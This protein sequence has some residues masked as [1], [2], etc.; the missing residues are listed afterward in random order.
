MIQYILF[1]L[2][3]VLSIFI[4]Q[5]INSSNT[6][7]Y[8]NLKKPSWQPPS[9]LFPIV[10]T[11]LYLLIG[12]SAFILYNTIKWKNTYIWSLFWI[13]LII[14]YTWSYVFFNQK[15]LLLPLIII[16]LLDIFVIWFMIKSYKIN[17]KIVYFF[18]PYLIWILFATILF[19][20]IYL[21]NK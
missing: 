4:S 11:I 7:W 8:K 20:N 3:L 18:L 15:K 12:Y 10:W 1:F 21:L 16:L 5:F 19:T 6:I 17:K 13:Q 14:N 9:F 2:P